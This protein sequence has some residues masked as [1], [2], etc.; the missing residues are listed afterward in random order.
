MKVLVWQPVY[1][2]GGGLHV[3]RRMAAAL[4]RHPAVDT[5]TLAVNRD[6]RSD[7]FTETLG[8]GRIRLVRIDSS[9]PL[10]R[11]A[12]DHDVAYVPWPHGIPAA[13]ADIPRVCVFQ[14][15]I[16]LDAYGGHSSKQ[17]LEGLVR[18]VVET[19]Q[20]HSH[21]IVTSQ[22][23]RRRMLETVGSVHA[24][25]ISVIP[26]IAT[27][28]EPAAAPLP[29]GVRPPY[30]LYPANAAEHKNHLPL[31]LALAKRRHRDVPLV[32]CGYGTEQ[33]GAAPLLENAYLNRV[34]KL[35]R[36]RGLLAGRD[37]I[38]LGFVTDPTAAALLRSAAGLVMP[39]RAEGMGL[40]IH[41]AIEARVPV[42]CSDIEVLR[43][44]YDERSTAIRWIDPE[45]PGEIAAAL[46]ELAEEPAAW[47]AKAAHNR[48]SGCTWDDLADQTAAVLR[49]AIA[50][51]RP[52]SAAE[53]SSAAEARAALRQRWF[54]TGRFRGPRR[55]FAKLGLCRSIPSP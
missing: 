34:N 41:D 5:L 3:L 39:T 29:R 43:E 31:L 47:R 21:V 23:S 45:C 6:Y 20:Q 8:S 48:G 25:A 17:F 33:I 27:E 9:E 46:D 44:H 28:P 24:D 13:A 30:F 19:V 42:V 15:T 14:D 49:E 12:A 36:D 38:N 2:L 50:A 7:A 40:P 16:L 53:A 10:A 4:A 18:S 37:F 51:H 52:V 1:V 11:H 35:I 22:Y 55:F 26:L 32:V 54:G